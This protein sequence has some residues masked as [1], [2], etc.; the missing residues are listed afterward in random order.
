[1]T[2]DERDSLYMKDPRA[3]SLEGLIL[4]LNIFANYCEKGLAHT[5]GLQAEH[6]V[7][8]GPADNAAIP[9]DS[10]EGRLLIMLGW[11]YEDDVESWAYFT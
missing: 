8:Y 5:Y 2:E 3:K 6:D 9:E 7:L 1:M 4:A 10:Q 11:H